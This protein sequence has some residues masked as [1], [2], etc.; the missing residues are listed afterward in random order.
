MPA[1]TAVLRL[2]SALLAAALCARAADAAVLALDFNSR[3]S[4]DPL[5]TQP[6]F[7]AFSIN[8]SGSTISGVQITLSP[9]GTNTVLNDRDRTFPGNS[10]AFTMS[11]VFDDFVF[12]QT[13]A[14]AYTAATGMDIS[15]ARLLPATPYAVSLYAYDSDSPGV[16]TAA[17]TGNGASLFTTS[18]DGVY[19]FAPA[20]DS[21]HRYDAV[22]TTDAAGTLTLSGRWVGGSPGVFA[23]A[24]VL[25]V[26]PEPAGAIALSSLAALMLLKR[27]R[28][29]A[30]G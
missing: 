6:G 22:A 4:A 18:F 11:E 28:R 27:N 24:L 23:D 25:N 12:A 13:T 8:D 20:S 26:V 9:A 19:V 1:R 7:T 21:T 17:W 3:T 16:R 10:G 29:P 30:A 15:L 2:S 5:D 14:G